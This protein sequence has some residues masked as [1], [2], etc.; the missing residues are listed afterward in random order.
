MLLTQNLIELAILRV[1]NQLTKINY[2]YKINYWYFKIG[3]NNVI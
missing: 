1:K 2:Y 3:G